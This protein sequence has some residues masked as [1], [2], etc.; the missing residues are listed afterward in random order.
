MLLTS[1]HSI[2]FPINHI[3]DMTTR[4]AR[5]KKTLDIKVP[6]LRKNKKMRSLDIL[7]L[8]PAEINDNLP[9][10][11]LKLPVFEQIGYPE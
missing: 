2:W 8:I 10:I 1:K 7:V 6:Y 3:T 11:Y 9:K 4:V 5:C